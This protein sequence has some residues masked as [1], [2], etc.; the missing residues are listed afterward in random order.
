MTARPD[1]SRASMGPPLFSG[2]NCESRVACLGDYRLQWGR[3]FSAAEMCWRSGPAWCGFN[4]AAAFQRRK[5]GLR[6]L[7]ASELQ[8]GRR[9]SAAEMSGVSLTRR[10]SHMS[11]NGAAAFQRRK[12]ARWLGQRMYECF[13]GAAAFQRRKSSSHVGCY[14]SP[15]SMGP[16]LFSGGNARLADRSPAACKASMGPP[17]FSGGN[18]QRPCHPYRPNRA[19]MGPPLFSGGNDGCRGDLVT[20]AASMG[21]PLFSGGNNWVPSGYNFFLMTVVPSLAELV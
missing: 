6:R 4:G 12:C 11:F 3:R 2:G 5:S 18:T 20:R 19:S 7:A 13:N 14:Q 1:D 10:T 16:P 21:P 8:W 17:L 15:A 9:F